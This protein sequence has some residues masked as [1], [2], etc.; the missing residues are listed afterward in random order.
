MYESVCNGMG[1]ADLMCPVGFHSHRAQSYLYSPLG[2]VCERGGG[3]VLLCDVETNASV[4][5]CVCFGTH[6]R[7]HFWDDNRILAPPT[8][9]LL[10]W[11]SFRCLPKVQLVFNLK[12]SGPRALQWWTH[13]WW[14]VS[15]CHRVKCPIR[16]TLL[17]SCPIRLMGDLSF[18]FWQHWIE[19]LSFLSV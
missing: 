13:R 12:W 18:S 9:L 1:S 15:H 11:H 2:C 7:I 14:L 17:T 5:L 3:C 16:R 6:K 8:S 19:L 10:P 4:R